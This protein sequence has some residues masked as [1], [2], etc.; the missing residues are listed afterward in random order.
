MP[1]LPPS[2][3]SVVPIPISWPRCAA[4]CHPMKKSTPTYRAF[5]MILPKNYSSRSKTSKDANPVRVCFAFN[6]FANHCT[7][8]DVTIQEVSLFSHLVEVLC[9]FVRQHSFRSKYFIL[10][11][12][13]AVRVAQLMQCPQK[14]MKLS[15]FV[16]LF[17]SHCSDAVQP[18]S[19]I[20]VPA[21]GYTT[22]S[23]TNRS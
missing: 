1:T 12:G 17:W 13:L 21:S 6:I 11:E 22:T 7:V 5:T 23:T 16:V 18:L 20:F 2:R 19:N 3:P 8:N 4:Q 14:H 9:F 15:R 10:S